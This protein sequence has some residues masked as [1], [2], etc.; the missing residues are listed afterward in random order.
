MDA[1]SHLDR[2]AFLQGVAA[3]ASAAWLWRGGDLAPVPHF[4][5]R[6]RRVL[7]LHMVGAPSQHDL[8]DH[9]PALAKWHGQDLPD[10]VRQGQR[11]T[12]MTSG[13]Q[14]LRIQKTNR[15]FAQRGQ[16]GAW[17]SDLLPFTA[18][19]ADELAIVRSMQTDAINHEPALNLV[20]TG[21]ELPGRPS[22][23][24]WL[25]WAIGAESRDLPAFV[26]LHSTWSGPKVDQALYSRLWGA[27]FLPAEHQ[28]VLL[29]SQGDPVLFLQDPAGVSR[30]ARH[31]QL[32]AM[33]KLNALAQDRLGDPGIGAR[34]QQAELAFRMQAAVPELLALDDESAAAQA[35]YGP[36]VGR[37]GTFA[38][39]ALLARR[40]LERGVRCV[41]I[42]HRGWDQHQDLERNLPLQCRDVDQPTAA[43][44]GD[45][46]MRGMLDDTLVVWT[47][48]FG[49]TVYAQ[50]EPDGANYGRD[51]HP[52]CFVTWLAGGGVRAGHQ[53]GETDEFG[54]NTVRDPV[55]VHDLNA[56]LLC[57]LG[58][59]HQRLTFRH[60]GRD[61]R[62]T[63]VHGKVVRA[64]LA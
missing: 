19:H 40:L 14:R 6:A 2:R 33:A 47:S 57:L 52:R 28:G 4:T 1:S 54:Y 64:L 8:F 45:L 30:D 34:Q 10:S 5:P 48:E 63:D 60:E 13:Q 31:A 15:G 21:H 51:H 26:V 29:R 39:N 35:S 62:L 50:G 37:R 55:H 25:A 32:A 61:H 59:D 53:H 43:L 56:T 18:Q 3:G 23:G 22:F 24:A 27:G 9:K 20:Q 49:R 16:C 38:N 11:I 12:T 46:R 44:L 17:I 36:D 41:Q 58:F 42:Y 7:Y